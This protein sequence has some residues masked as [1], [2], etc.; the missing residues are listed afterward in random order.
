MDGLSALHSKVLGLE[1][2]VGRMAQDVSHNQ[3]YFNMAPS[4]QFR[5]NQNVSSS[6]R[7]SNCTP[8]PSV[9]SNYRA[10]PLS[11]RCRELWDETTV[12]KSR[13]N[14]STKPSDFCREPTRN[15]V[16][17]PIFKGLEKNVGDGLQSNVVKNPIFKGLEKNVGDGLRSRRNFK[18]SNAGDCADFI[19]KNL[20]EHQ[21][22]L[23]KHIKDF[24]S[25]G[26]LEYAFVEALC[27]G[28]VFI[29]IELM[30][31]TGPVLEQLSHQ[32]AGEI[33]STIASQL[34]E[35]RFLDSIIPWLHQVV[36]L[37][38][39][40]VSNYFL[41]SPKAKREF[42]SAIQEMAAADFANSVDKR[43]IAELALQLQLLWMGERRQDLVKPEQ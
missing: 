29:L 10:S 19:K 5:N 21:N 41:L 42:L 38:T 23:W 43:S 20:S 36:D 31:R 16:K 39:K 17:N 15:V 6:P 8:R 37:S 12:T 34:L 27:C 4:K 9:D 24:L 2:M 25:T 30:N 26:D 22:R 33:L 18:L 40:G 14:T 35:P 32:T 3:N 13:P 28:D 7:F 1:H 11:V